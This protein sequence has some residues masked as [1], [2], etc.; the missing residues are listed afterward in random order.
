MGIALLVPEF[1]TAL[2]FNQW[3]QASALKL[4]LKTGSWA[5]AWFCVSGGLRYSET[6]CDNPGVP[7]SLEKKDKP[8]VVF[9]CDD[10]CTRITPPEAI[11]PLGL[12]SDDKIKA[13]N[14]TDSLSKL[15][16]VMQVSWF[17]VQCISRAPEKLPISQLEIGTLAFVGCSLLTTAFWWHKPLDI[18][19]WRSYSDSEVAA[20]DKLGSDSDGGSSTQI[21][22]GYYRLPNFVLPS[23]V[24]TKYRRT[25]TGSPNEGYE[26]IEHDGEKLSGLDNNAVRESVCGALLA[27]L[28]GSVHLTAWNFEFP[29]K[30][31]QLWWRICS[32][33]ITI[34]PILALCLG[35]AIIAADLMRPIRWLGAASNNSEELSP[36]KRRTESMKLRLYHSFH[37]DKLEAAFPGDPKDRLWPFF[38][39]IFFVLFGA[40]YCPARALLIVVMF[41]SFQSMAA[42]VYNT[43]Q[44]TDNIMHI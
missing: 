41:M 18:R 37:L 10:K 15:I 34:L 1:V 9:F 6:Y 13:E 26:W 11:L 4:R 7:G 36:W 35:Y 21:C 22:L 27:S 43:V 33:I 19:L 24:R 3:M 5:Q 40:I 42:G 28:L 20:L 29:T 12:P 30:M 14:K 2:A 8:R 16:V 23:E 31:E 39:Y 44:W 32:L 25:N 38:R 17:T